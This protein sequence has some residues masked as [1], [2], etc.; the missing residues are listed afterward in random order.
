MSDPAWPPRL[1]HR[2]AAAGGGGSGNPARRGDRPSF[3]ARVSR[4]EMPFSVLLQRLID[5]VRRWLPANP[6]WSRP[7]PP[8]PRPVAVHR[9]TDSPRDGW[10]RWRLPSA[11]WHRSTGAQHTLDRHYTPTLTVSTQPSCVDTC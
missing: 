5:R 7:S 4:V 1:P 8:A 11:T 3:H 9:S 6:Y 10:R 2:G